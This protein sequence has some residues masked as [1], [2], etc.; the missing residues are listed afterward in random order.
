VNWPKR[1]GGT[2][3]VQPWERLGNPICVYG[4]PDSLNQLFAG[5]Q[6]VLSPTFC[7]LDHHIHK[8]LF[9]GMSIAHLKDLQNQT[10]I[11][12]NHSITLSENLSIL[13]SERE[14]ASLLA[15]VRCTFLQARTT[16]KKV[17]TWKAKTGDKTHEEA[18]LGKAFPNSQILT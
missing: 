4:S 10:I 2:S 7:L 12:D 13:L 18:R 14:H 15:Q 9:S 16:R 1:G 8:N 11:F 6:R 17:P 3:Q 5:G